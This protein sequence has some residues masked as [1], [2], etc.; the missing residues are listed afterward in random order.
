MA[1][2]YEALKLKLEQASADFAAGKYEEAY[3][4]YLLALPEVD[5]VNDPSAGAAIHTNCGACLLSMGNAEEALEQYN[6]AL[7]L[8]A[9]N[10]NAMHN[11]GERSAVRI[12]R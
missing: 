6:K 5:V 10:I 3:S 7:E 12:L 4:A 2:A 11:K 1:A 9:S 8:D